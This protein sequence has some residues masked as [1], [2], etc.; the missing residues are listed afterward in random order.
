LRIIGIGQAG[1]VSIGHARDLSSGVAGTDENLRALYI[2]KILLR[3]G[4]NVFLLPV[5]AGYSL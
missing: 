2:R 4:S 3:V 1:I 5:P